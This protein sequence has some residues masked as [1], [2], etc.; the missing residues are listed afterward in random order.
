MKGVAWAII[1][2][3]IIGIITNLLTSQ[4][5]NKFQVSIS[6]DLTKEEISK[7]EDDREIKLTDFEFGFK[8][9]KW[10]VRLGG[11]ILLIA[12]WFISIGNIIFK[13]EILESALK[14]RISLEINPIGGLIK[15]KVVKDFKRQ[16]YIILIPIYI[17]TIAIFYSGIW[18][19]GNIKDIS[20][21]KYS[22]LSAE[23]I[24]NFLLSFI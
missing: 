12:P 20:M 13:D 22:L 16:W 9:H 18:F 7:I 19:F 21:A 4:V 23:R 8:K 15:D 2:T 14:T 10:Y 3:I 17:L 11:I 5:E 1:A 6:D 24:F